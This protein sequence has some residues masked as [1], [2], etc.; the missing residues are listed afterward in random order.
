M[1]KSISS[2]LPSW[3]VSVYA[4]PTF[5]T[6]TENTNS[7]KNSHPLGISMCNFH[8][9]LNNNSAPFK[10]R[11]FGKPF[12][13]PPTPP[14][15]VQF[16]PLQLPVPE[17]VIDRDSFLNPNLLLLRPPMVLKYNTWINRSRDSAYHRQMVVFDG[18][19]SP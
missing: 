14:S 1:S 11:I 12:L 18:A 17:T 8:T 7:S 4:L 2:P 16:F 5:P 9:D 10:S 13:V 15:A 19:E 6:P 3:L